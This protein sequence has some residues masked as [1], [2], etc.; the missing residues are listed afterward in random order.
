MNIGVELLN[1]ADV[2]LLTGA[3][4]DLHNANG[5]DVATHRLIKPRFLI[6]LSG[7]QQPV[8]IVAIAIFAKDLHHGQKF[9]PFFL[10]R[11]V[12]NV[13]GILQVAQ[14]Y[15]ITQP[16]ALAILIDERIK[17]GQQLRAIV[18]YRPTDITFVA[19]NNVLMNL[20]PG[21]DLFPEQG[22]VAV[23]H[24]QWDQARAEHLYQILI[25]QR[26][27]RRFDGDGGQRLLRKACVERDQARVIAG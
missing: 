17:Q 10:P 26:F 24:D 18:T 19:Q 6:P 12:F 4:H 11:R 7:H 23:D 8:N 5:A 27:G 13:A 25:F 15:R 1:I 2:E 21:E 14:Q 16:A 20:N 9:T 3:R 22:L